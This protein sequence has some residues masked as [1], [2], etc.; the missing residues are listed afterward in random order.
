MLHCVN[1][2]RFPVLSHPTK[3]GKHFLMSDRQL[4]VKIFDGLTAKVV[5]T[6][7]LFL[8]VTNA[9]KP[10]VSPSLTVLTVGGRTAA[11]LA[12]PVF[13]VRLCNPLTISHL[14]NMASSALFVLSA[15]LPK[16]SIFWSAVF[17]GTVSY[18]RCSFLSEYKVLHD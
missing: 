18:D 9:V 6:N 8:T 12:E 2:H 11:S 4:T 5:R 10:T 17:C 15:Y 7:S 13:L 1:S 14:S 16:I 3:K